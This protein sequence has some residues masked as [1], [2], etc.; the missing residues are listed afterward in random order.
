V[1]EVFELVQR[2]W[3]VVGD[4]EPQCLVTELT[5]LQAQIIKLLGLFP[6]DY[7]R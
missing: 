4:N 2:H 6:A 3:L 7:G 5:T 1:I